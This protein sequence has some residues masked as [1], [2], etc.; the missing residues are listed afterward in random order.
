MRV[1]RKNNY[2]LLSMMDIAY[3]TFG[4]ESK[5]IEYWTGLVIEVQNYLRNWKKS[6][7]ERYYGRRL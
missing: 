2:A 5:K 6:D 1:K 3:R 7:A 4:I